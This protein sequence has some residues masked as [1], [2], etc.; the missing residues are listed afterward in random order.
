MDI[1]GEVMS[2]GKGVTNFSTG[3]RVHAC[4]TGSACAEYA[5]VKADLATIM[6]PNMEFS[7]AAALPLGP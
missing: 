2:C 1:A 3:D 6:P 4:T 5:V 7:T